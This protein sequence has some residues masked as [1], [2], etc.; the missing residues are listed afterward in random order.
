MCSLFLLMAK[1]ETNVQ[2]SATSLFEVD[3]ETG[4]NVVAGL[5]FQGEHPHLPNL[6]E[7]MHNS[8]AV[9]LHQAYNYG[10]DFYTYGLPDGY[11]EV[12][13]DASL[14]DIENAVEDSVGY[15]VDIEVSFAGEPEP[16]FF[17]EYY[18]WL[19][20]GWLYSEQY[21]TKPPVNPNKF[22]KATLDSSAIND[23][24]SLTTVFDLGEGDLEPVL[25]RDCIPT[26]DQSKFFY[27]VRFSPKGS[28]NPNHG[29]WIYEMGTGEYPALDTV[30]NINRDSPY[31][32]IIPL[33]QD[34]QNM[35]PEVDEEGE[36]VRDAD[37]NKIVP[38]TELY[39]TSKKLCDLLDADFDELCRQVHSNPDVEG[40]DHAYL[41]MGID[42]RSEN[43]A[44]KGYLY[45]FFQDL[46]VRNPGITRLRIQ[47]AYYNILITFDSV[48]YSTYTGSLT[49]R[50]EIEYSGDTMTLRRDNRD[51]TYG[52]VIVTNL[53]HTNYVYESHAVQTSL[54][55]S[56]DPDNYNFVI[57]LNYELWKEGRALFDR[58]ELVQESFKIIFNS[59]ERR[60]LKWYET[61]IFKAI[62]IV[63]AIVVTIYSAGTFIA[64]LQSAYAATGIQGAMTYA[65]QSIVLATAI[66]YGFRAL[67]RVLPTEFVIA[68]AVFATA[69]SLSSSLG[70]TDFV[71]ADVMLQYT[72]VSF[73]GVQ[74][75]IQTDLIEL[76]K[77]MEEFTDYTQELDD[78]LASLEEELYDMSWFEVMNMNSK[79]EDIY[80]YETPTEFYTRTIHA[81]NIGVSTLSAA[82]NYVENALTLPELYQI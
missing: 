29:Y 73:E 11:T 62:M 79:P 10:R 33:R 39:E 70:I 15:P 21:F 6:L 50:T 40:I 74:E 22:Y 38:T 51:G 59:Y 69:L 24:T 57:P 4:K 46:A 8:L 76:Q 31:L 42:I 43:K 34:N 45:Q 44:G 60:K 9:R 53:L 66:N 71:D 41:I 16:T 48:D 36:F 1:Y 61:S 13:G 72:N 68:I 17:S 81:G 63:I 35:G 75:S 32:P 5:S 64:G 56:A 14:Q 55:G 65:I 12:I 47:D 19:N 26:P 23:D 80:L 67:A 54:S 49:E 27:H 37:G 58:Y 78:E 18:G 25:V 52:E 20:W 3:G 28:N 82:E 77:E 7:Q 2:S 30:D